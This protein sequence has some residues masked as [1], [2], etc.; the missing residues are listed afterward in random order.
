MQMSNFHG[1]A[2]R[3]QSSPKTP[4]SLSLSRSR[5]PLTLTARSKSPAPIPWKKTAAQSRAPRVQRLFRRIARW[6]WPWQ[7]ESVR[8]RERERERGGEIESDRKEERKSAGLFYDRFT[9]GRCGDDGVA[10]L[11]T[12]RSPLSRASCGF[13]PSRVPERAREREDGKNPQ[14][15]WGLCE[16][17]K[18]W[19]FFKRMNSRVGE[20]S[21]RRSCAK[22]R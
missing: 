22:G 8:E 20:A 13:K 10:L 16:S 6:K 2:R 12:Y 17:D 14:A 9:R 3:R 7:R 18:T 15:S 5:S 1:A 21:E 4:L 19:A 11:C